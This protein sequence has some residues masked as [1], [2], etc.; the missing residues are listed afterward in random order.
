M[1]RA[2]LIQAWLLIH[3]DDPDTEFNAIAGYVERQ[4]GTFVL[5]RDWLADLEPKI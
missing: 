2:D 4:N 1:T 5:Y 3:P